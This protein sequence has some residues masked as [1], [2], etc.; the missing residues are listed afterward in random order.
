MAYPE[1]IETRYNPNSYQAQRRELVN[2]VDHL[3]DL[4]IGPAILNEK[5]RDGV[6]LTATEVRGFVKGVTNGTL[7]DA[8][9]G[10][11]L[12]Y[13]VDH[14]LSRNATI[15]LTR[16]MAAS[17]QVLDFG[18]LGK[19]VLDKHSSGGI[20]DKTTLV[21]AP[22]VAACG[23]VVGKMSGRG[24]GFSGGTLDKLESIPGLRT[25]FEIEEFKRLVEQKGIVVAGQTPDMAPADGKLYAIRD[26]TGTVPSKAL[27]AASIMSKKLAAG[28]HVV[29]LDVKVGSG[30]FMK[31]EEEATEL[32]QLMVDIGN[33][34]GVATVAELTDMNQPL[35]KNVGNALEVIEAIETLQ[36]KGSR[37]FTAHCLTS[38]A[39]MLYMG[40]IAPTY[41]EAFVMAEKAWESGKALEKFA[42]MVEIQGGNPRVVEDLSLLPRAPVQKEIKHLTG[43]YIA[44]MSADQIGYAVVDLGGGRKNK[45]DTINPAVGFEWLARIGERVNSGDPLAIVHARTE[46]DAEAATQRIYNA[47]KYSENFVVP[48]HFVYRIIT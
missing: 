31:T 44:E 33:A 26:V 13:V 47:I 34:A 45:F 14:G 3:P 28:P 6:D 8:Q 7:I 12:A 25:E 5:V 37:E 43:G 1:K 36:G 19:P 29:L 17:G 40:G 9:I 39:I 38:A 35:G 22:L 42:L 18:Y 16:A 10:A 24:L 11:F 20:G 21:V 23:G 4:P 15:E 41:K 48:P 46:A 30:T 27:I 32:A 2:M